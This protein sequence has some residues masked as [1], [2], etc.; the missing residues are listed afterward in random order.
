[1]STR[2]PF[3]SNRAVSV[4]MRGNLSF[5]TRPEMRLRRQLFALGARY[6]VHQRI[7]TPTGCVRPDILFTRRRVAVFVDGCFWH[8]CPI[9]GTT[10]RFN[11]EYWIPK[12][13]RNVE[14]DA[15]N[16]AN[17]EAVGWRVLRVW[18]HEESDKA[19]RRIYAT[20]RK[21]R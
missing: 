5:D 14:R 11:S 2:Y 12:L 10:P 20:V 21:E 8:C 17:L 13:R 18:E 19:A 9:H 15:R 1:V 7:T 6:R 4:Q 16:A 3:P